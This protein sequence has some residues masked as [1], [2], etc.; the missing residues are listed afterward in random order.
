LRF[1]NDDDVIDNV[2]SIDDQFANDDALS[3][4]AEFRVSH[5]W[6]NAGLM[7]ASLYGPPYVNGLGS[8][9]YKVPPS[10]Y[11]SGAL[12]VSSYQDFTTSGIPAGNIY[13]VDLFSGVGRIVVGTDDGLYASTYGE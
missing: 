6:S 9:L 11:N 3:V 1:G 2:V 8:A 12:S 10:R 7:F 13:F 5:F 4:F